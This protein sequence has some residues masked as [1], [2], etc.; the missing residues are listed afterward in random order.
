VTIC[1]AHPG[2]PHFGVFAFV[3]VLPGVFAFFAGVLTGTSSVA[4][5]LLGVLAASGAFTADLGVLAAGLGASA[6]GLGVL[7]GDLGALAADV[8]ATAATA[9]SGASAAGLAA[10]AADLGASAAGL[11]AFAADLGAFAADL[12]ASATGLGTLGAAALG[13][14]VCTGASGLLSAA[15]AYPGKSYSIP[16][17]LMSRR[18][19]LSPRRSAAV[20]V[21]L[22]ASVRSL[23]QV[24]CG[25]SQR[26]RATSVSERG[27]GMR[28]E[29]AH[30]TNKRADKDKE[31]NGAD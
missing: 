10:F 3:G 5:R 21:A 27:E 16:A 31:E 2:K 24:R 29:H 15:A 28:R 1:Q 20:C 4:A 6:A 14:L 9:G 23:L 30:H 25:T 8:G 22:S 26:A 13:A 17:S 18:R 11:A 19:R 7:A 12:G